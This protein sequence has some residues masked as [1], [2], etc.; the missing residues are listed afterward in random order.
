[1][2]PVQSQ[3]HSLLSAF[4][5]S[6]HQFFNYEVGS[7]DQGDSSWLDEEELEA[8]SNLRTNGLSWTKV[9]SHGVVFGDGEECWPVYKFNH[10]DFP[11]S[12][13]VKFDGSYQSYSGS[14]YDDFYIVKP[15][16]RMVTFYE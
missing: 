12:V 2:N 4:S 5:A 7:S 8:L 14:T 16:E 1:M 15:V 3:V 6:N 9:K 11:A 13:Y 10:Y